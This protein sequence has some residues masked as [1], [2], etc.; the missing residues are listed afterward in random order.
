MNPVFADASFYIAAGN[1]GDQRHATA[2]QFSESYDGQVVTTEYV[3][4]EVG[5]YV[6]ATSRRAHFWHLVRQLQS[7]PTTLIVS[8]SP[9]LWARGLQLYVGRLDKNW[10]LT[11]CISFLVMQEHGLT[12]ALTADHHFEQAGFSILLS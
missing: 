4:L 7:D 5:N 1:P 11:D 2:R 12:R 9:E 10:S 6:S 8:S 3:L